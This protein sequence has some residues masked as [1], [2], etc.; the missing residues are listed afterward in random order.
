MTLSSTSQDF[1][2]AATCAPDNDLAPRIPDGSGAKTFTQK[3]SRQTAISCPAGYTT[4]IVCTPTIPMACYSVSYPS[5]SFVPT[6][7]FYPALYSAGETYVETKTEFPE[8][9]AVTPPGGFS[10]TT[11]S[12]DGGRFT[13][14][15]AEL[16]STNNSLTQYGV[17]T[18]A[19]TPLM[20]ANQPN[21]ATTV[22]G[23][24]A[25][26]V[27]SITGVNALVNESVTTGGYMAPVKDGAYAVSMSN[28]GGAGQFPFS[29]CFDNANESTT[30]LASVST[31]PQAQM[32]FKGIPILWDNNFDS[33]VFRVIVPK[34]VADQGFILKNWASVEW[35]CVYGSFLYGLAQHPPAR[36]ERAFR[37]YSTIQDN[38]P[39]AVP[40]NMNPD[41]WKSVLS[42][43][44]PISGMASMIPGPIGAIAGGVH[45]VS[46]LLSSS[47]DKGKMK[48]GSYKVKVKRRK[49][50]RPNQQQQ[51][52]LTNKQQPRRL[53]HIESVD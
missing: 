5:G 15:S 52:M 41:F 51:N 37:L 29:P 6:A 49:S 36:D 35:K 3:F 34:S 30:I 53:K 23:I 43:I 14:L 31:N 17:I 24:V 18:C 7:G 4:L 21:G 50:K 45:A 8:W 20:L 42:M 2:K 40:A 32:G 9:Y 19:K 16:K 22:T 48:I 12:V 26:S 13:S 1:I 44:K 46:T 28:I 33:I 11:T 10:S 27:Y 39:T 25:D 38:L 47:P